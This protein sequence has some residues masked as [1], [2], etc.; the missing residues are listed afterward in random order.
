M[1]EYN[2][3]PPMTTEPIEKGNMEFIKS[4][5]ILN[6]LGT[7]VAVIWPVATRWRGKLIGGHWPTT[8]LMDT[9]E[10]IVEWIE[11]KLGNA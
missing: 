3:L 11:Q 9:R 1:G 6:D 4:E 7:A 5:V 8:N 10:E 2:D